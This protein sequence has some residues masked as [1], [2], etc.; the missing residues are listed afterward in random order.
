M[1][2]KYK[3]L[4]AVIAAVIVLA[5]Y[6]GYEQYNLSNMQGYLQTSLK[7]KTAAN[8][9]SNQANSYENRNDYAKAIT[10]LQKSSEETSK[11]LE[12]DNYAL[13]HANGIYKDYINNDILLLKTTSKL[14]DFQIYLDQEKSNDLNPGQ[15]HVTPDDLIPHINQL[16]DE[17]LVYK[18]NEDKIIDANPDQFK[19]LNQ[20]S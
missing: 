13:A 3:I 19:F 6:Y 5:G 14:I 4:I 9:Y 7:Y 11:A 1:N 17:I 18:T 16:E 20:S 8:D 15:E 12:S 2:Q 10:M